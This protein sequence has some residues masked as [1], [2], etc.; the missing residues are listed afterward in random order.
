MP[1]LIHFG[2]AAFHQGVHTLPTLRQLLFLL[3]GQGIEVDEFVDRLDFLVKL[4]I[5]L[6]Q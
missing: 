1:L 2:R 3:V 6:L 4:L 5:D